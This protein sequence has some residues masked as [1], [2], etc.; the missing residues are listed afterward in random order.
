MAREDGPAAPSSNSK[1]YCVH[2]FKVALYKT[3]AYAR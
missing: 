2:N 1:N 3:G